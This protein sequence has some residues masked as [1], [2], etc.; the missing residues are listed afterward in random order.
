VIG[1]VIELLSIAMA[2]KPIRPTPGSI[3]R[4]GFNCPVSWA[5]APHN[6]IDYAAALRTAVLS[7][8]AG[9]IHRYTKTTAG[10]FGSIDPDGNG[11]AIWV[12]Y[13]L[14]TG[15]P[16]YGLYGHTALDWTDS[17]KIE[18]KKFR[19]NCQYT[20]KWGIGARVGPCD[21]L[22]YTAPFY[23]GGVL[24]PHLHVS[25]FKP[26]QIAVGRY[27]DPPLRGWGYSAIHVPEGE[28][29]NPEEFFLNYELKEDG[30]PPTFSHTA[31]A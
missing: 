16:I 22:G 9:V 6:G 28:Y 10:R 4:L 24:Q 19:F 1:L 15:D 7:A 14:S 11:P 2:A 8:G 20:Q 27:S 29:V 3:I 18:N 13:T 23:N 30:S 17:S 25:I 5:S 21:C 26:N 12:R 31:Y